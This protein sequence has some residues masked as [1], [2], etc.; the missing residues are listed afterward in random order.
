[1]RRNYFAA[2]MVNEGG[3]RRTSYWI[4][5]SYVC[6]KPILQLINRAPGASIVATT[7]MT[8]QGPLFCLI[9]P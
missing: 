4:Y 6:L 1:M 2:M 7:N 9:P 8:A 5:Q 3:S